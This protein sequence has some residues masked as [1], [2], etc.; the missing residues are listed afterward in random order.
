MTR[1]HKSFIDLRTES[2]T[3]FVSCLKLRPRCESRVNAVF[4]TVA[5]MTGEW[6]WKCRVYVVV[7]DRENPQVQELHRCHVSQYRCQVT[8]LGH[9]SDLCSENWRLVVRNYNL[10]GTLQLCNQAAYIAGYV[11]A[12]TQGSEKRP[13][14]R[15]RQS[16]MKLITYIYRVLIV[17]RHRILMTLLFKT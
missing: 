10:S 11:S 9:N 8:A 6:I 5:S 15:F 14:H 2:Y 4:E 7:S 17:Q 12:Y 16:N 1:N 13:H 3:S